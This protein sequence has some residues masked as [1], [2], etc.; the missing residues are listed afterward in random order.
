MTSYQRQA[1]TRKERHEWQENSVL[2]FALFLN[3]RSTGQSTTNNAGTMQTHHP[4][5]P[6]HLLLLALPLIAA[7]CSTRADLEHSGDRASGVAVDAS[8]PKEP[9]FQLTPEEIVALDSMASHADPFFLDFSPGITRRQYR[10][11]AE[12]LTAPGLSRDT[13]GLYY[14]L[15]FRTD[16]VR[17]TV[18]PWFGDD[19]T[20]I[21]IVLEKA[22]RVAS[23]VKKELY[24][25]LVS[26]Y[27]RSS[28][29]FTPPPTYQDLKRD[30]AKRCEEHKAKVQRYR[31]RPWDAEP[32]DALSAILDDPLDPDSYSNRCERFLKTGVDLDNSIWDIGREYEWRSK[33]RLVIMLESYDR[34]SLTYAHPVI[35]KEWAKNPF[36]K[37][38]VPEEE[39]QIDAS[40]RAVTRD[41]L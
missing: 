9:V 10:H 8:G 6:V 40:K 27:G 24:Q 2:A 12:R 13:S 11:L 17:M 37:Y 5:A 25:A 33:E 20:L 1:G 16:S 15:Y 36:S 26:K 3:T 7:A 18:E 21:A 19:S 28:Q 38:Y 34:T 41:A 39:E 14:T 23:S 35:I 4:L 30:Y 22:G 31:E 32:L 29:P